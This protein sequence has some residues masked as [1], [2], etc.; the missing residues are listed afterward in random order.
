[1]CTVKYVNGS[2]IICIV[3]H[4]KKRPLAESFLIL[5]VCGSTSDI[6]VNS[7]VIHLLL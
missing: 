3:L 5:G 2:V 1:M 7:I 4:I 6:I